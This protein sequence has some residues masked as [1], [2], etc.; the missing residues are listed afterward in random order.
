MTTPSGELVVLAPLAVLPHF[1]LLSAFAVGQRFVGHVGIGI[2]NALEAVVEGKEI[3]VYVNGQ[4]VNQGTNLVDLPGRIGLESERGI[5]Q[6]R[7][8]ALTP[9]P[10]C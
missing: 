9:L 7:N 1:G 4:L 5:I 6:F 8:L 2:W 10:G 3:R